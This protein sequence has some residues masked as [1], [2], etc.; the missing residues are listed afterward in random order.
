M[1]RFLCATPGCAHVLEDHIPMDWDPARGCAQSGCSCK[2]F[3][4][5]DESDAPTPDSSAESPPSPFEPDPEP[6]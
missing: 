3:T 5:P 1:N 6:F 2:Q 4:D